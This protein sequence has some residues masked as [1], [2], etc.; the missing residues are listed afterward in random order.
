[1]LEQLLNEYETE[2]EFEGFYSDY[3]EQEID[4]M[5]IENNID[6]EEIGEEYSPMLQRHKG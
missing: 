3:T 6:I 4:A 5:L 2:R 1:M